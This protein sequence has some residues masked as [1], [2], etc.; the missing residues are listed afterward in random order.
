M[1][2]FRTTINLARIAGGGIVF[3]GSNGIWHK[4]MHYLAINFKVSFPLESNIAFC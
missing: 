2:I 1:G 4:L 3:L